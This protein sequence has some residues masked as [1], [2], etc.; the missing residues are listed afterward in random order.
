[1]AVLAGKPEKEFNAKT[2]GRKGAKTWHKIMDAFALIPHL[3]CCDAPVIC[4][5]EIVNSHRL[6]RALGL[7][8]RLR[9]W[10]TLDFRGVCAILPAMKLTESTWSP[11]QSQEVREICAHLTPA[12]HARII[13]DARQ[14]GAD[15][16]RWI[17]VPF[18]VACGFIV[19]AWQL[20]VALLAVFAIYFAVSGWSRLR[21][22]R[23]R[24]MELLCE[25]EWACGRGYTPERLRLMRFPGFK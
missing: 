2:P 18:G 7:L 24:S 13:A 1:L 21:A 14:R 6:I 4:Q 19:F 5:D 8:Y 22:M 25:T 12:E 15:I 23:R 3:S 10:K 17:A 16:G 11:F 20:G 9:F